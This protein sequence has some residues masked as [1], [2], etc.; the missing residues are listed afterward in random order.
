MFPYANHVGRG[1]PWPPVAP[2]V[3]GGVCPNPS[4]FWHH[5][6]SKGVRVQDCETLLHFFHHT[7]KSCTNDM[8]PKSRSM[9]LA[10]VDVA[11]ATCLESISNKDTETTRDALCKAVAAKAF[12]LLETHKQSIPT[13]EGAEWVRELLLDHHERNVIAKTEG[14]AAT[15]GQL[16]TKPETLGPAAT[17]SPSISW[18]SVWGKFGG[19][20][21][22]LPFPP[23]K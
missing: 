2:V 4:S 10:N 23:S 5:A 12:E 11:A 6:R 15:A 21:S 3:I 17:T 16:K 1:P 20:F 18:P 13:T 9:M 8:V 14:D 19:L 22:F 7:L